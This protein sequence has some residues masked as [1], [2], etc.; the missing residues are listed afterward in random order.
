VDVLV[1]GSGA[2]GMTAALAVAAAGGE[3]LIIEKSELYGGSTAL[4]GGALWAPNNPTLLRAGIQDPAGAV[5]AYLHGLA[6]ARVPAAR[7]EAYARHAGEAVQFL[8]ESSRHL[9][10]S[11]VPG[12][13]DYHPEAPGGSARGRTIEPLPIDLRALGA[14]AAQLRPSNIPAP[15]GAYVTCVDSRELTQ[16]M[17][18]LAGV[19]A[20][21]RLLW[22][23]LLR[24]VLR[25]R[26]VAL[27]QALV[28][29]FRLAIRDAGIPLWLGSP[30]EELVRDGAGRISGAVVLRDGRRHRV[31]ARA[32]VILATGG[33][34]HHAGLRRL[35]FPLV[36][37]DWSAGSPDNTGDG[38]RAGQGVGAATDLMDDAWWMPSVRLPDGNM[39]PLVC[40]RCIPRSVVVNGHGHRFTNES[41]P[42]VNFVHD[43]L[44]GER[45]GGKHIP[46]FLILDAVARRRYQFGGVAPGLPF[47]RSW[48]TS[49]LAHK[50]PSLA[51]LAALI[52]VPAA[53]LERTV[54]RFN[55]FARAGT[56][57]DFRRGESVY[58]RYYGD[59]TLPN[60]VLDE[61]TRPP[62]YAITVVPGDLGTKG[63]LVCDEWSRVLDASGAPIPGLYATGNTSASVMGNE[64]AGAGATIGPAVAFGWI[65]ANHAVSACRALS[66]VRSPS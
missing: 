53:A 32:G 38:I 26:M 14:D 46:S 4:S 61:I 21:A 18:T 17:R 66:A 64:Y 56:D 49:G 54:D 34:D 1:A 15:L 19:K 37:Q 55:G 65:A 58:D 22:R 13:A 59:P 36:P 10:F 6:G 33:F 62:F 51:E 63:G 23:G 43:Q 47:P 42:Y 39:F 8:E 12:Y 7:I 20:G 35:H 52:G 48:F 24:L 9:R 31:H 45:A 29:R 40:E 60:P 28:A 57:D 16:A 44:A 41:A 2:G 50:A 3:A 11:Y 27:G 5:S 25:R 30:L